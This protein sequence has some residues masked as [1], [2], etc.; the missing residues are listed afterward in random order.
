M[1]SA[2]LREMHSETAGGTTGGVPGWTCGHDTPSQP[3]HLSSRGMGQVSRCVC[4]PP[5]VLRC[6]ASHHGCLSLIFW[7]ESGGGAHL[8]ARR[9]VGE[10]AAR[11]VGVALLRDGVVGVAL[12]PDALEHREGAE[13][14]REVRRDLHRAPT[15]RV[16]PE[17]VHCVGT[18]FLGAG[19]CGSAGTLP[20]WGTVEG[21][22]AG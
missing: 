6:S 18:H 1:H 9:V 17:S 20:P 8:A 7:R 2:K 19:A 5:A 3:R 21:G 4:G 10:E 22:G 14:V 11:E 13:D 12:Q 15:R 16:T